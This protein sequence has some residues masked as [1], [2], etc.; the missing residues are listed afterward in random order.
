[1]KRW[2]SLPLDQQITLVEHEINHAIRAPYVP[3]I[4]PGTKGDERLPKLKAL[5]RKLLDRRDSG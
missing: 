4:Y 2:T 1:M 5:R 3:V